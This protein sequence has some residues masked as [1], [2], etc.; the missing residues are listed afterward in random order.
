MHKARHT[1][2]ASARFVKA[3]ALQHLTRHGH[4]WLN[5]SDLVQ[6][7]PPAP[8][9]AAR[10]RM[11]AVPSARRALTTLSSPRNPSSVCSPFASAFSTATIA[12]AIVVRHHAPLDLVRGA[13]DVWPNRKKLVGT[14]PLVAPPL[15]PGCQVPHQVPHDACATPSS[16]KAALLALSPAGGTS[17]PTNYTTPG[18]GAPAG[19]R[20]R[21]VCCAPLLTI[22]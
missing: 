13:R 20:A 16:S 21:R 15:A 22:I 14:S 4:R 19:A 18:E 9:T 8:P 17:D 1:Q 2:R 11:L 10:A 6:P 12:V 3:P 5:R 7:R